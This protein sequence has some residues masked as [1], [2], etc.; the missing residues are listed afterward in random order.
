MNP[1]ERTYILS[2]IRDIVN[3]NLDFARDKAPHLVTVASTLL[4]FQDCFSRCGCCTREDDPDETMC[5][6]YDIN[7]P[8]L[9]SQLEEVAVIS[10]V[11]VRVFTRLRENPKHV[12]MENVLTLPQLWEFLRQLPRPLSVF[13][14]C[15]TSVLNLTKIEVDVEDEEAYDL[16]DDPD[17]GDDDWEE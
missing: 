11:D 9:P 15:T 3:D 10:D 6:I 2:T 12:V 14:K 7:D 16:D 5:L 4:P 13:G 8:H 17:L 1:Q